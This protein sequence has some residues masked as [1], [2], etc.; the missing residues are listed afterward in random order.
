M[1][2]GRGETH[3]RFSQL[4]ADN[5]DMQRLIGLMKLPPVT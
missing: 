1:R 3:A 2:F 5:I 4:A